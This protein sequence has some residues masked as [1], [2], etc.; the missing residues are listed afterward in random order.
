MRE[1]FLAR[2]LETTAFIIE[3]LQ[4]TVQ[5]CPDECHIFLEK[6]QILLNLANR[7]ILIHVYTHSLA[8]H[9]FEYLFVELLYKVFM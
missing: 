9:E 6:E 5:M 2:I 8:T 3:L 7:H 1:Q 4:K